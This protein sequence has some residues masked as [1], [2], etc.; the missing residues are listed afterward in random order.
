MLYFEPH[1]MFAA[2]RTSLV[3]PN[4]VRLYGR[5]RRHAIPDH[6]L[7]RFVCFQVFQHLNNPPQPQAVDAEA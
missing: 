6:A 7:A 4:F 2:I 5:T 1:A 3:Y